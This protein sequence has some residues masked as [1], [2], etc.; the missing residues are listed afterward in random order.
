MLAKHC[1]ENKSKLIHVSSDCVFSGKKGNYSENDETD[2]NDLYGITK[3][4]GE[5]KDNNNITVR[6]STI[7]FEIGSK[8]GLLVVSISR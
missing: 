6:T 4:A 2:A 1:T 3:A 7:G 8:Y 5:I